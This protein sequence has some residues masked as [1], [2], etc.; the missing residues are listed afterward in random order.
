MTIRHQSYFHTVIEHDVRHMRGRE[1]IFTF[2]IYVRK[3]TSDRGA[4]SINETILASVFLIK[5]LRRML[6]N[7]LSKQFDALIWMGTR[8]SIGLNIPHGTRLVLH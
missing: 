4:V 5:A 2:D 7:R 6:I 3:I 1:L 8:A